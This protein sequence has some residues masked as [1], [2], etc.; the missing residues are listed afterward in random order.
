MRGDH[1]TGQGQW[2][3]ITA[4]QRVP[5]DHPLGPIRAMADRALERMSPRFDELYS[6]VGRPSVLP[7]AAQRPP[8]RGGKHKGSFLSPAT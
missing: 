3:F 4:E 6:R 5:K 8:G 7:A 1:G 2:S